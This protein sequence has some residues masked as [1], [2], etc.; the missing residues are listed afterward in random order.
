MTSSIEVCAAIKD[1]I[2]RC[3]VIRKGLAELLNDPCAGRMPGHIEVQN[4]PPVMRNDEE[5]VENTEGQ[6]RHGEEIHRGYR[7]TMIAQKRSPSLCRLWTPR[8]FPHPAQHGSLRN[9]EAEHLQLAVNARR[10]PGR[11]L[12]DHAEDEFAQF[13]ADAFSSRAGPMPR[14][15]RPIQLEPCPMPANDGLRLDEDQRP[16]P[17]RPEPPQDDPEQ[18]IGSGKPRLRMSPFQDGKLLPKRQVFQEQVAAR[19]KSSDG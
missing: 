4:P 7:F 5:A 13:P 8:R 16:F 9:V 19:A 11:I 14:K 6:R 12:G 3:R 15:P 17:S 1:Q 2:P 18:F 10:T